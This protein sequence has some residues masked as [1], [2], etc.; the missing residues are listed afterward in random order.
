MEQRRTPDHIREGLPK[1]KK[2]HRAEYLRR[3]KKWWREQN[4]DYYKEYWQANKHL[5]RPKKLP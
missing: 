5:Y 4:P 1:D 3:Y 2:A